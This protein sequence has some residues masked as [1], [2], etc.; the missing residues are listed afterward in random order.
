MAKK[1]PSNNTS[2]R[3]SSKV[4]V[5]RLPVWS[6]PQA[7]TESIDNFESPEDLALPMTTGRMLASVPSS[8]AEAFQTTLR[9]VQGKCG[10]KD[11]CHSHDFDGAMDLNQADQAE[12]AIFDDLSVAVLSTADPD[13]ERALVRA[14]RSSGLIL[15]AERWNYSQD[16]FEEDL[17]P[18]EPERFDPGSLETQLDYLK[19][20]RDGITKVI[21]KLEEREQHES[22]QGGFQEAANFFDS[23]DATWGLQATGVLG[24]MLSGTGT[25]IAVL[26]S[27]VHMGH[28]DIQS[29]EIPIATE[30]FIPDRVLDRFRN[31]IT[32]DDTNADSD[33]SGHGTHCIG[34]AAGTKTPLSGARYG[35]ASGAEVFSAKVLSVIPG[36]TRAAG[37]DQWIMA[38]MEAAIKRGCNIISMSLGSRV[39]RG[40]GHSTSYQKIARDALNRGIL[41]FAA[42]GNDSRRD[43]FRPRILPVSS[44]ANCPSI[45]AVGAVVSQTSASGVHRLAPF[46]NRFL[47]TGGGEVNF[48]AP[49]FNVLSSHVSSQIKKLS[50]T[51]QATPHV[52]GIAALVRE[53][54]N[55]DGLPL[56]HELVK[57]SK[58]QGH[59]DDYGRGLIHV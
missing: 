35:V 34:T 58:K 26:D 51:R 37:T 33:V 28:P 54:K 53:D 44:P 42:A 36:Q 22:F 39:A 50:G 38:G 11:I 59:F 43:A 45:L 55:L 16:G 29:R 21:R 10:M 13:Q 30:T 14:S 24:T 52:T 8:G 12:I 1:K 17:I 40:V 9:E 18:R 15:E 31:V 57:R 49:G 56:F 23:S 4:N 2:S 3:R 27:G 48:C 32:L 46:T 41:I 47:N 5:D 20:Y 6:A 19:G 7:Q 25:K